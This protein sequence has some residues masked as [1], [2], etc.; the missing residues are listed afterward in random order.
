M[1]NWITG[2][3]FSASFLAPAIPCQA[4]TLDEIFKAWE[5]RSAKVEKFKIDWQCVKRN[6]LRNS[7]TEFREYMAVD[8]L[9][10]QYRLPGYAMYSKK[11]DR[12]WT[13][14]GEEYYQYTRGLGKKPSNK[15]Y[16]SAIVAKSKEVV[17]ER[18]QYPLLAPLLMHFRAL[19]DD[20]GPLRRADWRVTKMPVAVKSRG[21]TL[22]YLKFSNQLTQKIVWVDKDKAWSIVAM[23]YGGI[24]HVDI[25]YG[26]EE[27][28]I[29]IPTAWRLTQLKTDLTAVEHTVDCRVVNVKI[30]E[31]LDV[32]FTPEFVAGTKVN[33]IDGRNY[34]ARKGGKRRY[35]TKE[36]G[37]D[38]I[39]YL[40]LVSSEPNEHLQKPLDKSPRD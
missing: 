26:R 40:Q 23:E 10:W 19:H 27:L 4:D 17:N 20:L 8:G 39:E 31:R 29:P 33:D 6:E 7:R 2:V 15:V 37:R 5:E 32:E 11:H 14:N 21:R 35:I 16:D 34:I 13:S 1:R 25:E 12:V 9:N 22:Y 3:I 38:G 28:G 24:I 18:L 30:N 36:E